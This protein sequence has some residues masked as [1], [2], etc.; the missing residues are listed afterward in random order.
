MIVEP[1]K[2]LPGSTSV[3]C[4][5][6]ALVKV[7][8]LSFTR[9][10]VAGGKLDPEPEPLFEGKKELEP[11]PQLRL[12]AIAHKAETHLTAEFTASPL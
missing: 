11:E 12:A 1:N 6:V 7:S 3:A 9:G 4:W 10:V 5:L 2:K 8:V